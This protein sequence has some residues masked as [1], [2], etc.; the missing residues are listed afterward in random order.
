MTQTLLKN[1]QEI[2]KQ[3][4]QRLEKE[5]S[6]IKKEFNRMTAFGDSSFYNVDEYIRRVLGYPFV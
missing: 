1:T 3:K 2:Q 6:W 4:K 5:I